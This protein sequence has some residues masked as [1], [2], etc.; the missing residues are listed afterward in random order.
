MS[1][2]GFEDRVSGI[3]RDFFTARGWRVDAQNLAS[4]A[5]STT[6]RGATETR[7]AERENIV[8]WYRQ[9]RGLPAVVLNGHID[10]VPV[11]DEAQWER[12][13]FSGDRADG[14]VHGRG[15]VDTKGGIAAA[16]F[17]LDALDRVGIELPFDVAVE[18]VVGEETTGVGTQ[19]ALELMP[20]R[21]ATIVLEPTDNA[22][23]PLASGLL[24][25]TV[26]VLGRAAHTSVPWHGVD[27]GPK[28][29]RIYEA[30]TR[31]GE[32][33][34]RTH[35]H[36]L[37]PFPSAVPLA[38][39]TVRI[40]GWRAAVPAEGLLSGRIGVLPGE[41]LQTVRDLL[42]DCVFDASAD[43]PWLMRHPAVVQWDHDGLPS[44]ETS[45]DDPVVESLVEGRRRAGFEDRI[46]GMTAGCDAGLLVA[47]GVPTVVFGPGDMKYAHSPNEK[48]ADIDVVRARE[49]LAHS[50]TAWPHK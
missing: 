37:M 35:T 47:S 7:T 12:A 13:P 23:V 24:F 29:L 46:E 2:S 22:V 3:Y 11:M 50:L 10:V 16:L 4:A 30:L 44:W 32:Q 8:G 9:P 34:A 42:I 25:F 39:G 31:L 21:L 18:L 14:F 15:S 1:I 38:I 40:G 49:I 28:I 17:A 48:I 19:A 33:R 6:A 41:D 20:N 5:V 43:D 45:M 26:E 27:V 36:S